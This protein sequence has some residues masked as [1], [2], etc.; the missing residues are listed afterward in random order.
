MK[1]KPNPKIPVGDFDFKQALAYLQKK[2]HHVNA[3][4]LR[5]ETRFFPERFPG[6]CRRN[7]LMRR[8][9]GGKIYFTKSGLDQ[10]QSVTPVTEKY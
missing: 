1:T 3:H 9:R 4:D 5:K 10:Y 7:P 6:M 2:G 8:G